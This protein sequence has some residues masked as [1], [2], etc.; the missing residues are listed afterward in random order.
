MQSIS[1]QLYLAKED[2]DLIDPNE[3]EIQEISFTLKKILIILDH[4]STKQNATKVI[5]ILKES[6]VDY[7]LLLYLQLS[8]PLK[9]KS[10]VI[11]YLE[12]ICKG[13]VLSRDFFVQ[14]WRYFEVE[15]IHA[16]SPSKYLT[17]GKKDRALLEYEKTKKAWG[18]HSPLFFQTFSTRDGR[19]TDH[20]YH[21]SRTVQDGILRLL[22]ILKAGEFVTNGRVYK[23][24][25]AFEHVIGPSTLCCQLYDCEIMSNLLSQSIEETEK[26]VRGFPKTISV[27]LIEEELIDF[28]SVLT[29]SV[30]DKTRQ[31]DENVKVISYFIIILFY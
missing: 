25:G 14:V 31:V 20:I 18:V 4:L 3:S 16:I 19:F 29:F 17:S 12:N 2:L 28:E 30:K 21:I 5:T 27:A 13:M 11:C 6:E 7:T 8:E 22:D 23:A 10:E 26:M 24:C 1:Y 15:G 9:K